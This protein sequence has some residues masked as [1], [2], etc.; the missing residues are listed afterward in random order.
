MRGSSADLGQFGGTTLKKFCQ[1]A[2]LFRSSD[3]HTGGEIGN[4]AV[5]QC[6]LHGVPG[7]QYNYLQ[8]PSFLVQKQVPLPRVYWGLAVTPA[9]WAR[10][11][12]QVC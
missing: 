9:A 5:G 2:A 1:E 7:Q 3:A 6:K 11:C 12:F 8:H 4:S 10:S